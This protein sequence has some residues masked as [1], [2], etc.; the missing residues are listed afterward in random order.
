MERE[1]VYRTD[2]QFF[3]WRSVVAWL[4]VIPVIIMAGWYGIIQTSE[5][6]YSLF[7]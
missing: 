4:V 3:D 2:S 1:E 6:I 5:F 7:A